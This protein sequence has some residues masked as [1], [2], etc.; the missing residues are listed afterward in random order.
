MFS[1]VSPKGKRF[2]KQVP[3]SFGPA[4]YIFYLCTDPFRGSTGKEA[5]V[6]RGAH[7]MK[8]HCAIYEQQGHALGFE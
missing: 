1:L 4:I 5:R 6:P 8:T 2:G 7:T 3:E